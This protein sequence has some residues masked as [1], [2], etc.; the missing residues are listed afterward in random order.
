[1]I[2]VAGCLDKVVIIQLAVQI[3]P[4][5]SHICSHL[6]PGQSEPIS[7]IMESRDGEWS[8]TNLIAITLQDIISCEG[9]GLAGQPID[10]I[11]VQTAGQAAVGGAAH[12]HCHIAN[13]LHH[14]T[15][16]AAPCMGCYGHHPLS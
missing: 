5:R 12:L 14:A 3:T 11:A 4:H 6:Y 1:M 9:V 10:P 15:G 13:T 2:L 7:P 8:S 16:E